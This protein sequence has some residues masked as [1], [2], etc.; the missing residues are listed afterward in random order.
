MG[1]ANEL[2]SYQR[3][4]DGGPHRATYDAATNAML[5]VLAPMAPHMTAEAWERRHGSGARI[6]AEKWPTYDAGLVRAEKVTMVVQVDGKLR[7]RIEVST[8]IDE[9]QA[10]AAALASQRVKAELGGAEPARVVARPP[11]LVN[12]VRQQAPRRG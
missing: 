1:F 9:E 4:V 3:K 7:D 12:V 11:R 6:H 8:D 5:L 2:Q 10:I